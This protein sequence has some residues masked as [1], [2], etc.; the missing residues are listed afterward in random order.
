MNRIW[1]FKFPSGLIGS[2]IRFFTGILVFTFA[3]SSCSID[4]G[5]SQPNIDLTPAPSGMNTS[6]PWVNLKLTGRLIYNAGIVRSQGI[7]SAIQSLDLVTGEIITIFQD[8]NGGWIND[9]TI[10]PDAAALVMSY[11]P[12]T[13]TGKQEA[14]Y[15]MPLDGSQAPQ[16]FFTPPSDQD[17]YFQPIWS[18]DGSYIYFAHL[19][20]QTRITYEIMRIA[21]PSGKPEKVVDHAYWPRLSDDGTR[22]VYV[23]LDSATGANSLFFAN[24]DG[25][26]AQQI[27]LTHLPVPAI[28]DAPMFSEDNQSVLFS[29]PLGAQASIPTWFDRLMGVT[30]V[31][32]DGTLPSD[33]WSVPLSG[34]KPN[35]LTRVRSLGLFGCFSP[36]NK[37]VVSYSSDGIFVMRPDGTGVTM[38]IN[39]VG[40]T[41]GTVSWIP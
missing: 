16:L 29:S 21:Y 26:N 14:L 41:S 38:L 9:L 1:I 22:L 39:D 3:I 15:A 7:Y 25:T 13:G 28:I 20:I 4:I 23:S 40:G 19:S 36:D 24:A 10:S 6:V 31:A 2:Y 5:Q 34:G 27:P 32:A 17:Q 12:P 35:R 37:Y 33:W 8:L 18:P 30:R 11:T